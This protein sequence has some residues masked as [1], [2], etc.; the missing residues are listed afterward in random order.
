VIDPAEIPS[1]L[2]SRLSLLAKQSAQV[3]LFPSNLIS[4]TVGLFFNFYAFN[5]ESHRHLRLSSS[6][7]TFR[8]GST[9]LEIKRSSANKSD[10]LIAA[11]A[12][13]AEGIRST[14]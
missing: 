3:G 6:A 11:Q 5:G 13:S 1:H 9:L 8:S 12:S 2:V 4:E 14:K 7:G 10:W